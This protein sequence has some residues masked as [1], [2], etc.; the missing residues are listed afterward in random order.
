MAGLGRRVDEHRGFG[1]RGRVREVRALGEVGRAVPRGGQEHVTDGAGAQAGAVDE[2]LRRDGRLGA[3]ITI[4]VVVVVAH[5]YP[6]SAAARAAKR[7][8]RGDGRAKGNVAAAVLEAALQERHQRVAVDDA[9]REALEDAGPG[10]HVRLAPPGFVRWHE[11]RRD[12]VE[13]LRKVVQRQTVGPLLRRL[14]HDPFLGVAVRDGVLGA[15]RVELL[16]AAD[17]E[18]GLERVGAVVEAGV[19]DLM[20]SVALGLESG[21]CSCRKMRLPSM[22]CLRTSELRL[23]VSIPAAS[24]FSMSTVEVPSLAASFLATA[25]PTTP[26]PMT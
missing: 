25:R 23:L 26:P 22:E 3:C 7:L 11:P 6:I 10:V 5:R 2:R 15:E 12:I 24:C 18:P 13:R 14:G 9:R 16:P 1:P 20:R 21:L 19:D 17:A 8:D 4:V